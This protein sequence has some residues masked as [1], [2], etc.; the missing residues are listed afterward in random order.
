MS[1][2]G[3]A[4]DLAAF[5]AALLPLIPCPSTVD[6]DRLMF[7]AGQASGRRRRRGAWLWPGTALAAT[8]L[9]GTLGAILALRPQQNTAE[10]IVYVHLHQQDIRSQEPDDGSAISSPS[11]PE[12]PSAWAVGYL[13]LGRLVLAEGIRAIPEPKPSGDAGKRSRQ[14]TPTH[15]EILEQL[16]KG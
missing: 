3:I 6:R 4:P 5:E 15:Q 2:D 8:L 12:G 14:R 1:E 9:A 13:R 7:L 10:R 16:M 11:I